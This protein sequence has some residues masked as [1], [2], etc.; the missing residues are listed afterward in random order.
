MSIKNQSGFYLDTKVEKKML[1]E[2]QNLTKVSLLRFWCLYNNNTVTFGLQLR[3]LNKTIVED[4][5]DS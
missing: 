5:E 2:Q 1:R 3:I 4:T